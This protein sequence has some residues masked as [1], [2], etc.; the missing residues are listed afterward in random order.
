MQK[1]A[2]LI[3]SHNRKDTTLNCL[4]SLYAAQVPVGYLFEVFLVDDG[5][6]DG[7]G[8]AVKKNFP[9]VFLIKGNGELFWN[10]GMRLAWQTACSQTDYEYYLWLNDDTL[11]EDNA[12]VQ[13]F[14]VAF[15]AAKAENKPVLVT[16][17]CR[18]RASGAGFTY[19]GRTD[20]G[21]VIPNGKI[22]S[23]RYING[24]IVLVPKMI[25]KE[26]GMLAE[27]YTHALGDIDYGLF[28][29]RFGFKCYT[30]KSYVA[31]CPPNP[32]NQSWC[33]PA[34]GISERWKSFNEPKG[35]HIKEYISFR[36]KHWPATYWIYVFKAYMKFLFPGLYQ[37]LLNAAR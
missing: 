16:G 17:A 24:N 3:T 4:N 14:E 23:C 5:S 8:E 15:E 7:T 34:V 12:L 37:S 28:A 36:K 10:Q 25:F 1:I 13:L 22:Q 9:Q 33:N 30:T 29:Q 6:T 19:G 27:D 31:S 21:P 2:I 20:F 26:V 11:I 32:G 18:D 35:L